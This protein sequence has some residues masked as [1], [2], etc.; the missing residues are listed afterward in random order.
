MKT[1][2]CALLLALS[3]SPNAFAA[4]SADMTMGI[5]AAREG[6][7]V[8]KVE[9]YFNTL[10]Y[11][12]CDSNEVEQISITKVRSYSLHEEKAP[13]TKTE[14]RAHYFV[15][16]GCYH[17]STFQGAARD[18]SAAVVIQARRYGL[19]NAQGVIVPSVPDVFRVVLELDVTKVAPDLDWNG[20]G[21]VRSATK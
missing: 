4:P 9:Q 2:V 12:K 11:A 3:A 14:Y 15:Q 13:G 18:L 21:A 6:D 17:G 16:R 1:S 5:D 8:K 19:E 20:W 7:L 10:K